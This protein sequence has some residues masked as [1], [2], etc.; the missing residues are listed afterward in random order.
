MSLTFY[1]DI[2]DQTGEDVVLGS[3]PSLS[4]QSPSP[5]HDEDEISI[6]GVSGCSLSRHVKRD[7]LLPNIGSESPQL[8]SFRPHSKVRM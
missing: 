8:P 3:S 7:E 4:T 2:I 6:G 5:T 1:S